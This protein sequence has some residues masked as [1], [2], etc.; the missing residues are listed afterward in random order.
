MSACHAVPA[1]APTCDATPA[2]WLP[3]SPAGTS[4]SPSTEGELVRLGS[5]CCAALDKSAG[6]AA[7]DAVLLKAARQTVAHC[8]RACSSTISYL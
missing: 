4:N 8:L 5:R 1:V 6:A 7:A 3:T 2:S